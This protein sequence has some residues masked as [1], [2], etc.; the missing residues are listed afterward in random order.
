MQHDIPHD[1]SLEQAQDAA[2]KVLTGYGERF[3]K[4]APSLTWH[5]PQH[6]E[7]RFTAKGMALAA[8]LQ[9]MADRFRLRMDVPFLLRPF[10]GR[11]VQVID[12]QVR[13]LIVKAKAGE[14]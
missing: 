8:E 2:R 12:T 14:L 9:I 1:L 4:Y 5:S 3:A 13:A 6:A 7:L 10:G 11:A